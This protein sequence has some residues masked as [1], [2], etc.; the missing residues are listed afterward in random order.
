MV[1]RDTQSVS[2]RKIIS[3]PSFS[4]VNSKSDLIQKVLERRPIEDHILSK[5]DIEAVIHQANLEKRIYFSELKAVAAAFDKIAQENAL[6]ISNNEATLL[7]LVLNDTKNDNWVLIQITLGSEA[8]MIRHA[9]SAHNTDLPGDLHRRLVNAFRRGNNLPQ[10]EEDYSIFVKDAPSCEHPV[11]ALTYAIQNQDL[12][13]PLKDCN[14]NHAVQLQKTVQRCIMESYQLKSNDAE[15]RKIN[16]LDIFEREN[17]EETTYKLKDHFINKTLNLLTDADESPFDKIIHQSIENLKRVVDKYENSFWY[18]GYRWWYRGEYETHLEES[19][20]LIKALSQCGNCKDYEN[21]LIQTNQDRKSTAD[22]LS[23]LTD[24]LKAKKIL[25]GITEVLKTIDKKMTNI[26]HKSKY[27]SKF[28]TSAAFLKRYTERLKHINPGSAITS[29]KK[30]WIGKEYSIEEYRDKKNEQ[31]EYTL[32]MNVENHDMRDE[33]LGSFCQ[34][35]DNQEKNDGTKLRELEKTVCQY[36]KKLEGTP[37]GEQLYKIR[38]YQMSRKIL[39]TDLTSRRML[40]GK[41]NKVWNKQASAVISNIPVSDV[42][43]TLDFLERFYGSLGA[44]F[45][46]QPS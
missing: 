12:D 46:T 8:A 40:R 38:A 13:H 41:Y 2:G 44:F 39:F 37:L 20:E 35:F 6:V 19:K 33:V 31:T 29:N 28:E 34:I 17:P 21:L 43:R 10:F 18:C 25:S 22:L 11:R 26:N 23:S 27:H 1:M 15:L 4:R 5:S 30:S 32:A 24:K 9:D 45:R 16:N 3:K 36:Q 7:H 14:I 42:D